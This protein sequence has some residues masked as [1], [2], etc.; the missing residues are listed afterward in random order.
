MSSE[1]ALLVVHQATQA[2]VNN[3]MTTLGTV[4]GGITLIVVAYFLRRLRPKLL[5][6]TAI[7]AV[8]GA[9]ISAR[10]WEMILELVVYVLQWIVT[11]VGWVLD[12][13]PFLTGKAS[14]VMN[15][16]STAV[17]W[18]LALI[19]PLWFVVHMFPRLGQIRAAN[20]MG[21]RIAALHGAESHTFWLAIAAPAALLLLPP[22]AALVPPL[23][24]I[25]QFGGA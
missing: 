5:G 3:L 6:I 20:S 10:L 7:I 15:A 25:P 19:I 24:N 1:G 18:I 17:P 22:L 12:F 23:A 9:I 11:K 4:G 8:I 2:S 13:A 16:L 14:V 21:D